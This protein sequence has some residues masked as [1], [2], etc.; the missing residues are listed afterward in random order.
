M[1]IITNLDVLLG[2]RTSKFDESLN[3]VSGRVKNFRASFA[4]ND[5][6]DLLPRSFGDLD[7]NMT[8]SAGSGGKLVTVLSG[9]TVVGGVVVGLAHLFHKVQKEIDAV[10]DVASSMGLGYSEL[11]NFGAALG[12]VAGIDFDRSVTSLATLQQ[13]IGLAS[14]GMGKG[15]KLLD[16]L[17]LD[18]KELVL[19]DPIEQFHAVAAAIAEVPE[20]AQRA[21]YAMKLFG[22][23]MVANALVKDSKNV[24]DVIDE[25]R[26]ALLDLSEQETAAIGAMQDRWERLTNVLGGVVDKVVGEVSLAVM[27]LESDMASAIGFAPISLELEQIDPKTLVETQVA[28][29]GVKDGA[30]DAA[31]SLKAL[32]SELSSQDKLSAEVFTLVDGLYLQ[33]LAITKG[34]EA[35]RELELA[36]K[37]FNNE[38]IQEIM[39]AEQAL[40]IA[41]ESAKEKERIA[42]LEK[43]AQ[44]R[45]DRIRESVMTK[46]ERLGAELA[47]LRADLLNNVIDQATFDRAALQARGEPEQGPSGPASLIRAGTAEAGNFMIEAKVKETER[48]I[49]IMDEQKFLAAEHLKIAKETNEKIGNMQQLKVAR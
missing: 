2:A 14:M 21:A 44:Q 33:E 31:E 47:S 1:A 12:E 22:D 18:P 49:K 43:E 7:V 30:D 8:K 13:Q 16:K 26:I 37:G 25:T 34:A 39:L 29:Q 48:Q 9:L 46:Q 15:G 32:G 17:G 24:Q 4:N 23:S 42:D 41:E 35:A 28:I 3:K 5:G 10:S 19:K 45:G 38:Q 20:P 6:A 36:M 11:K 27:Q 40:K